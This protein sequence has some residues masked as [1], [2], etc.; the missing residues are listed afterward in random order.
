MLDIHLARTAF[1]KTSAA[2]SIH[3]TPEGR[4]FVLSRTTTLRPNKS[5]DASGASASRN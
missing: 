4:L 1:V 5:L 2:N 3:L